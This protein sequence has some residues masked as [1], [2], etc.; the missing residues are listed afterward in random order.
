MPEAY[1]R[2]EVHVSEKTRKQLE[3]LKK[4]MSE[5]LGAKQTMNKVVCH[6]IEV[7]LERVEH[8]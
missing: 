5:K 2:I 8:Q 1:S 3:Q 4:E 7:F 6:I